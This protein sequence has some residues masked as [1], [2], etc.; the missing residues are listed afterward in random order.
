MTERKEHHDDEMGLSVS[1]RFSKDLGAIFGPQGQVPEDID[2]AVAEA[3]RGHFSRQPRRLWWVRWAVAAATTAA[4][5]IVWTVYVPGLRGPA[6][7]ATRV[8]ADMKR[9]DIDRNGRV[10]IIDAFRLARHIESASP[11]KRTWDINGDGLVNRDD[12]DQVA[13]AAVRLNKGV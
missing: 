11:T 13:R 6:P 5:V 1:P 9:A 4:A 10:D 12:V 8:A 7:H 2:R 3:A